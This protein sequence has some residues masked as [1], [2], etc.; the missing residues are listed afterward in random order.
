MA[1]MKRM[2]ETLASG[3][4][5]TEAEVRRLC[6]TVTEILVEEPNLRHVSAPVT[7][8]G[9]IHGKFW[10]LLELFRQGGDAPHTSYVFIGDI[11]DRG[12]HNIETVLYLFT[13]KAL[14]PD[15][16]T[17]VRG[18]HESRGISK[19][20]G[21]YDEC[22][23]KFGS[24]NVWK[25]CTDTFDY[26]NLAAVVADKIFCVHGGLS[27]DIASLD[28]IH[29]IDRVQEIPRS[30][31]FTDLLWSDP[32][33]IDTWALSAR[34]TGYMFG[35]KVTSQ[36]CRANSLATIVRAHQLVQEGYKYHF[37][38]QNLV[39]VW[40][41]PNYCYRC[42][43]KAA[44]MQ[45]GDKLEHNFKVFTEVPEPASEGADAAAAAAVHYFL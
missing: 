1:A 22:V 25:Y 44:I 24:G 11:V 3:K 15:R 5:P 17:I 43:N 20:Y 40:S 2:L 6:R 28:Q 13:L 30:G 21:F 45:V 19:R 41:C 7:L 32:E 14:Y 33:E 27:P 12:R 26:L 18:N 34:G 42:G 39:T 35:A 8:C 9:D 16:M 10:D 4:L 36:F 38:D 37:P 23:K 29:T 31:P